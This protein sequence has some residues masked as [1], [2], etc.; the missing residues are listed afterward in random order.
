ML[1]T[2]R[3]KP[4]MIL[5]PNLKVCQKYLKDSHDVSFSIVL[6]S[7]ELPS[8]IEN[9]LRSNKNL[10]IFPQVKFN[11]SEYIRE[12]LN[13]TDILSSW[14]HEKLCWW[15][16]MLSTKHRFLSPL[17]L[18]LPKLAQ[19]ITAIQSSQSL[20]VITKD[21]L[22]TE[23]IADIAL[24]K[25]FYVQTEQ[26]S[27]AYV[28]TIK[29]IRFWKI[30]WKHVIYNLIKII[31]SKLLFNQKHNLFKS[32]KCSNL[33]KSF[34][35]ISSFNS[36]HQ[37][38]DPF[39]GKLRLFLNSGIIENVVTI[40]D[41]AE[42]PLYIKKKIKNNQ[43]NIIP[44]DNYYFYED[45]IKAIISSFKQLFFSQFVVKERVFFFEEDISKFL[46]LVFSFR[47]WSFDFSHYLYFYIGCRVAKIY[48][49]L[50]VCILTY[51]GMAWERMFIFGLKKV[52]PNIHVIG[53]QHAVVPQSALSVFVGKKELELT[54]Q[55]DLVLTTGEASLKIIQKYGNLPSSKIRPACALRYDHLYRVAFSPKKPKIISLQ[56]LVALDGLEDASELLYYAILQAQKN[57]DITFYVRNHP[58]IPI[59]TMFKLTGFNEELPNNM[60]ISENKTV[61][62]DIEASDIVLYW[63]TTI[64]LEAIILGL[65]VIHYDR[66]DT[67]SYDPLF[68]LE[69][70]KWK[71]NKNDNILETINE[72]VSLS[73]KEYYR[74]ASSAKKYILSYFHPVTDDSLSLFR[75]G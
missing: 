7:D 33:I 1:E 51:E 20:I 71:L 69:D 70:F 66:G 18:R 2:E 62:E 11:E 31:K 54:P 12:T 43:E 8:E 21:F 37:F 57:N 28:K 72:I 36:S 60:K 59:E 61:L 29:I 40:V 9:F 45:F 75:G 24:N 27:H 52:N 4:K 25:G 32:S 65:P 5:A 68:D 35:Y 38:T 56:V 3:E 41:L 44:V 22:L 13:V 10:T 30:Y 15:S 58:V 39:F 73:E 67:L 48:P 34:S 74:L 17:A 42:S 14:N 64:S 49:N 53:Y 63:G 6:L 16:T 19:A 46:Q 23:G 55:P 50:K 47:Y 26:I